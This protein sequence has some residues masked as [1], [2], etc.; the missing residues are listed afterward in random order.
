MTWHNEGITEE[1]AKADEEEPEGLSTCPM[2]CEV[3]LRNL[4]QETWACN[5]CR[6]IWDD[7]DS[8]KVVDAR[9]DQRPRFCA[10][11][12]GVYSN[13]GRFDAPYHEAEQAR[14]S[15]ATAGKESLPLQ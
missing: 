10:C 12:H 14:M 1:R 13:Q 5:N 6:R 7:P 11:P 4:D 3:R 15:S 8:G 9:P 2:N